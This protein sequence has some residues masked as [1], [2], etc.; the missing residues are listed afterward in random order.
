MGSGSQFK[1]LGQGNL[2]VVNSVLIPDTPYG[3]LSLP[4]VSLSSGSVIGPEHN[5][6]AQNKRTGKMYGNYGIYYVSHL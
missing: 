1:M 2:N 4:G 3:H 5:C 6:M